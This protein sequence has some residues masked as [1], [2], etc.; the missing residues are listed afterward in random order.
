MDIR[1]GSGYFTYERPDRG[2]VLLL[3]AMTAA[4]SVAGVDAF[5]PYLTVKVGLLALLSLG[6]SLVWVDAFCSGVGTFAPRGPWV[7]GVAWL[8]CG[9]AVTAVVLAAQVLM[10]WSPG[11]VFLPYDLAMLAIVLTP[12]FEWVTNKRPRARA[13][14]HDYLDGSDYYQEPRS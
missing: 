5:M 3:L 13:K 8:A 1:F 11:L 12:S 7:R 2:W 6:F 10:R 9:A 4:L 14:S